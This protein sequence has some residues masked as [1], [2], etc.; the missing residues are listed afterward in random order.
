MAS[1]TALR[2]AHKEGPGEVFTGA[3][4]LPWALWGAVGPFGNATRLSFGE[5]FSSR[6]RERIVHDR[7]R[8]QKTHRGFAPFATP[9]RAA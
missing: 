1:A 7:L 3:L 6:R 2:I 5:R 8:Q 4:A 9:E